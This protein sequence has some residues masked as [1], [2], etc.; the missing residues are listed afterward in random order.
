MSSS[1]EIRNGYQKL[2]NV[3]QSDRGGQYVQ[4]YVP[5]TRR[6]R[7]PE[8][9]ARAL[10]KAEIKE[11]Y[12]AA[13]LAEELK[14]VKK[15]RNK[16]VDNMA[17]TG[18]TPSSPSLALSGT[19][20]TY[21]SSPTSSPSS[22]STR[23]EEKSS[24][25]FNE[26]IN[27][28]A[29]I[30]PETKSGTKPPNTR[31]NYSAP[32][33]PET[34]TGTKPLN[35]RINYS[36][37]IGPETKS[38]TKPLDSRIDYSAPIG[39]ETKSGTKPLDSSIN[40]SAPIGPETKSGTKPLN[41]RINYSAPIGPLPGPGMG[42]FQNRPFDQRMNYSQPI[43][44]A[45]MPPPP[46]S[47]S[48]N[49]SQPIGPLLGPG[50]GGFQNRPFDQRMNYSQPIG[51]APMP[52]P[53]FSPSRNYSQPIGPLPGPNMGGFQNRPF[54]NRIDYSQA[55]GPV[56]QS[57]R[58]PARFSQQITN[59]YDEYD[60]PAGPV[61]QSGRP[62]V[63][64]SPTYEE[65]NYNEPSKSTPSFVRSPQVQGPVTKSG[66]LPEKPG[67]RMW[68][69]ALGETYRPGMNIIYVVKKLRDL[70]KKN[71]SK[72]KG[73]DAAI[74]DAK[75]DK[76]LA[77][78]ALNLK[79]EQ[80]LPGKTLQEVESLYKKKRAKAV[81]AGKMQ[82]VEALDKALVVRRQ[83]LGGSPKKT[84]SGFTPSGKTPAPTSP[85]RD[86]EMLLPGK[87]E[88]AVKKIYANRKAK[89]LKKGDKAMVDRLDRA[90]PVRLQRL[91]TQGANVMKVSPERLIPGTTIEQV[92]KAYKDRRAAAVQKKRQ[93]LVAALDKAIIARRKQ[94]GGSPKKGLT[95]TGKT[96]APTSPERDAEMLLPGKT[97][98]AV[99]RI[100]SNRKAKALKKGDKAMVDRLDRALPVR[101]QRLKTQG[102][103]VMKVSPERLI[104]GVTIAEIEK[105][106]KDRRAA[107]VQKKRQALVAA[108][109]K[110]I[111]VRRKQ[112]GGKTPSPQGKK[113]SGLASVPPEV[114]LPGKT[115]Q[116]VEK[117]YKQKRSAAVAKKRKELVEAL[118]K[119]YEVRKKQ[120]FKSPQKDA[121][122][123]KRAREAERLKKIELEKK[124]TIDA[125][126]VQTKRKI[127]KVTESAQKATTN[128]Q[129][130]QKEVES[131]AKRR[132]TTKASKFS[133][134]LERRRQN[135]VRFRTSRE[136]LIANLKRL[137]KERSSPSTRSPIILGQTPVPKMRK[138]APSPLAKMNPQKSVSKTALSPAKT[139]QT[140]IDQQKR[141]QEKKRADMLKKQQFE[142]KKKQETERKRQEDA[143]KRQQ[144]DLKK[145]QE[146]ERKRQEDA[147]KRQQM[148]LKKKQE[149]ERKRQ[150]DAKKRQDMERKRQMSMQKQLS[151]KRSMVPRTPS[152]IRR[153]R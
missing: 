60:E 12:K 134:V 55:A 115:P 47:P 75:A 138:V 111:I 43:G 122:A 118:N 113:F 2:V 110:A 141:D 71:P 35:T 52:P 20:K 54:N 17:R 105:A 109:D 136:K 150:Q 42:G 67:G 9:E 145:K 128:V 5:N 15:Q 6:R 30:G 25:P 98:D 41:T 21:V 151:Q 76:R 101:L 124:K 81:A 144:S 65:Q 11:Q 147:K 63:R 131:A 92:E 29:P 97:E 50:M 127:K 143:K 70:K 14:A 86:A 62:P 82:F 93:A 117:V 13:A 74:A 116:N 48:R 66:T 133:K 19:P 36:A 57:G 69:R 137:E 4:V 31:I 39:P 44:P 24:L 99:R 121:E 32:I 40:Y 84:P 152:P 132:D 96:P 148:E 26:K 7:S 104:P 142:S 107:A 130:F 68:E 95:L 22:M 10:A 146:A 79:P 123:E 119:A 33:G 16:L 53:P 125:Q 73:Y 51:P 94:L 49:Y 77:I 140:P 126:I 90:L 27:Y 59:N 1:P 72:S 149:I 18:L 78:T 135:L 61:T 80:I 120:S 34:Q 139:T 64:T 38:G 3:R 102:A 45:P 100:Y 28:S 106:Y 103:N 8:A 112:L 58:R 153:K 83:Q 108:L 114:L 129:R 46:F 56:T 87:T 37:P 85:E 23:I 91:K 88:D 89:A